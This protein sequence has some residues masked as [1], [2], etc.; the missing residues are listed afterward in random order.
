MVGG[1]R[2]WRPQISPLRS[3]FL[4][5]H[6]FFVPNWNSLLLTLRCASSTQSFKN[7]LS[8]FNISRIIK[9]LATS[10]FTQQDGRKKR[11]AKRLSVT[12]VTA[13]FLACFVGNSLN[14]DVFWS[15]TKLSV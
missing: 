2:L 13:L 3:L 8:N 9:A 6:S 11:T 7:G 12:N 5:L 14:T 4:F 1:R 10:E 15:S